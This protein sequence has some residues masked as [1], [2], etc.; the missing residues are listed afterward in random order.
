MPA[1]MSVRLAGPGPFFMEWD[2]R[3]LSRPALVTGICRALV[4]A[5]VDVSRFSGHSFQ[6]GTATTA[7]HFAFYFLVSSHFGS[8]A[9]Q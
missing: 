3:P 1:Y 4:S 5:G 6:I 2:G 7:A 8:S 9:C